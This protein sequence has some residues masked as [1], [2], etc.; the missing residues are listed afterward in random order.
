MEDI[1]DKI[2]MVSQQLEQQKEYVA[3]KEVQLTKN[4]T[5][6]STLSREYT[7]LYSLWI[8]YDLSHSVKTNRKGTPEMSTRN[9]RIRDPSGRNVKFIKEEK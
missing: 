4:D 6:K 1:K 7:K 3:Y 5:G 8:L 2:K 9:R